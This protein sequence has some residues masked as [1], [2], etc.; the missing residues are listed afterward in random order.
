M[1]VDQSKYRK[2]YRELSLYEKYGIHMTMDGKPASPMQIAA[3]HMVRE[4]KSY[5]RDYVLDDD[6]HLKELSFYRL[7]QESGGKRKR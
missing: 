6:G 2:L 1:E 4:E 7:R 5:M 3:A